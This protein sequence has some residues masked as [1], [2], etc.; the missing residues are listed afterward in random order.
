MNL[1]I[2]NDDGDDDDDC[3]VTL[4]PDSTGLDPRYP[5]GM[6]IGQLE[7]VV[8]SKQLLFTLS[9]FPIFKSTSISNKNS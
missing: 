8:K 4:Y 9:Q 7:K 1:V 2:L 3:N 6:E 5:A